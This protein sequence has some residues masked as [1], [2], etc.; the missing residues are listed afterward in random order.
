MNVKL[1]YNKGLDKDGSLIYILS[2]LGFSILALLFVYL[3]SCSSQKQES[4]EDHAIN[5]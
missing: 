1:E 3:F 5:L 2:I 4:E